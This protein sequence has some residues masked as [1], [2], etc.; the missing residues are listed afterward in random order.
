MAAEDERSIG[1]VFVRSLWASF[2]GAAALA[3]FYGFLFRNRDPLGIG[4]AVQLWAAGLAVV[5]LGVPAAIALGH[6]IARRQRRAAAPVRLLTGRAALRSALF[7]AEDSVVRGARER[8]VVGGSRSHNDAYLRAIEQAL[9]HRPD[10]V[11][12]RILFGPARAAPLC[13][14]LTR[15]IDGPLGQ[16]DTDGGRRVRVAALAPGGA[17]AE[18]NLCASERK[19]VVILPSTN[20]AASLDTALM[21]DD[22]QVARQIASTMSGL[23]SHETAV[24]S[25]AAARGEGA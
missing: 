12:Y 24:A 13:D 11:Y 14:H 1:G 16:A 6:W 19:V 2:A 9:Q 17:V 15:L 5:V 18:Q 7:E 20:D 10:L 23:Y 22:P 8:I 21:V 25:A 3:T 4:G